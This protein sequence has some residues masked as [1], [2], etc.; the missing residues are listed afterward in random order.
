VP[1]IRIGFNDVFAF[2]STDESPRSLVLSGRITKNNSWMCIAGVIDVG[3]C[4]FH[5]LAELSAFRD[6]RVLSLAPLSNT[7]VSCDLS[8]LE[9]VYYVSCASPGHHCAQVL[10]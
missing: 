9:L 3:G 2:A 8:E 7:N 5:P 6:E 4:V 10:H 1:G